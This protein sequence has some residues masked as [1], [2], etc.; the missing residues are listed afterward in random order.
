MSRYFAILAGFLDH[1]KQKCS[2][3]IS[4]LYFLSH[5]I[6]RKTFGQSFGILRVEKALFLSRPETWIVEMK[7]K[8]R[9]IINLCIR[10]HKYINYI[11]IKQIWGNMHLL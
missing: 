2:R 8:K 1:R 6:I 3:L 11:N 5:K 4:C 7:K 9:L 10:E